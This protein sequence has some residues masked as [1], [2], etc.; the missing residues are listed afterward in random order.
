MESTNEWNLLSAF[1]QQHTVPAG[2]PYCIYELWAQVKVRTPA[3]VTEFFIF[4]VSW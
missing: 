4:V 2:I 1:I 3:D